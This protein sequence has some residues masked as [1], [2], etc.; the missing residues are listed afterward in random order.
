[1][2]EAKRKYDMHVKNMQK[3]LGLLKTIRD[4][5]KTDV[6]YQY[7]SDAGKVPIES[8]IK[9]SELRFVAAKEIQKEHLELIKDQH[10]KIQKEF[11]EKWGKDMDEVLTLKT[12]G[13]FDK[14]FSF[15]S[16]TPPDMDKLLESLGKTDALVKRAIDDYY[17]WDTDTKISVRGVLTI[18]RFYEHEDAFKYMCKKLKAAHANEV[19]IFGEKELETGAELAEQDP[20]GDAYENYFDLLYSEKA[21]VVQKVDDFVTN[22]PNDSDL[23]TDNHVEMISKMV[24]FEKDKLEAIKRVKKGYEYDVE[25]FTKII[26]QEVDEDYGSKPEKTAGNLEI[27][28]ILSDSQTFQ[29]QVLAIFERLDALRPDGNAWIGHETKLLVQRLVDLHKERVKYAEKV[30]KKF[31]EG[32][33]EFDQTALG[34]I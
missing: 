1:M 24:R 22:T 17:S 31:S 15:F 7:Y 4:E 23:Y 16:S 11:D 32:K 26:Q 33:K 14:I 30:Q 20:Y 29:T 5:G 2:S 6:D 18:K 25:D 12:K 3:V 13:F 21:E 19:R 8:I 34:S 27:S 9:Q 10:A 28:N